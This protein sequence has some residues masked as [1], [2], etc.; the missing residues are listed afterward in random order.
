M[1]SDRSTQALRPLVR[2]HHDESIGLVAGEPI[3]QLIACYLRRDPRVQLEDRVPTGGFERIVLQPRSRNATATEK[4][5][6]GVLLSDDR[7]TSGR[8]RNA[9]RWPAL[10]SP[11]SIWSRIQPKSIQPPCFFS[12]KL[13]FEESTDLGQ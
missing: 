2:R 7:R 6:S 12:L 8:W 11:P 5:I 4:A 10:C 9:W 1:P 13:C 3:A